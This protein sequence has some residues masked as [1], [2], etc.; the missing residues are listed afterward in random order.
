MA[1]ALT[2][3]PTAVVWAAGTDPA[4]QSVTIPADATAV[5]MF[6]SYWNNSSG[7]GLHPTST[8][9]N[10]NAPDQTFETAG[11]TLLAA[12]G[13]AVWYNPSTGSQSLDPTFDASP[14][15]GATT[16]VAYVK[17]GDTTAW[18]DADGD[19]NSDATAVS[20]TL[21]TNSDD[22][23]LKYDQRWD[24]SAPQDPPGTSANWTSRQTQSAIN[25]ENVRLSSADSPGASTT[26]CDSENENYSSICAVA[27]PVAP[28]GGGGIE[29]LRRRIEGN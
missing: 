6:W 14:T 22:L 26:V 9:L 12:T 18:G 24:N 10:G 7:Y 29:I 28:A 3:T 25:D 4:A 5:Y 17:G 23:V 2:G 27:I 21:T 8:L 19:H 11:T 1:V 15:E 16:I 13:V 20:V